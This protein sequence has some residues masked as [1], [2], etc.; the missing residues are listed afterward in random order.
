MKLKLFANSEKKLHKKD[1][2]VWHSP[3]RIGTMTNF[4]GSLTASHDISVAGLFQGAITTSGQLLI[5]R[6]A[7]VCGTR[8]KAQSIVV[9]GKLNATTINTDTLEL[10]SASV[11]E[12]IILCKKF[13][14]ERGARVCGTLGVEVDGEP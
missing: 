3:A 4:T 11:T 1:H 12:G 14:C 6:N 5:E 10:H 2:S 9:S 13:T 7:E 8:I